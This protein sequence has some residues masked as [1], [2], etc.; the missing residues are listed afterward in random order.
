MT[1]KQF[2]DQTGIKVREVAVAADYSSDYLQ[3][4]MGRNVEEIPR[5]GPMCAQLM[6]QRVADL[7]AMLVE[8]TLT[9]GLDL[10]LETSRSRL[11]GAVSSYVRLDGR[12]IGMLVWP[13][14]VE[15][16]LGEHTCCLSL[17]EEAKEEA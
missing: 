15:M 6:L 3:H 11:S 8:R 2:C 7:Q 17:T 14:G 16:P 10:Q 9:D 12:V 13:V 4:C 1:L 5:V